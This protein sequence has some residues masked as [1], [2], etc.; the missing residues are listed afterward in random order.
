MIG[1]EYLFSLNLFYMG[2]DEF[3]Q[4]ELLKYLAT[5]KAE[6]AECYKTALDTKLDFPPYRS[7]QG[8]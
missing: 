7:Y 2:K 1:V 4:T 5:H 3:S 6:C 8:T